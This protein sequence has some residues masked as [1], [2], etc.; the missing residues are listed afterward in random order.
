VRLEISLVRIHL[1][2][3]R[4]DYLILT[5]NETSGGRILALFEAC[6]KSEIG[7]SARHEQGLRRN[8]RAENS[9]Q[10]T[11]RRER[12]MPRVRMSNPD[13]TEGMRAPKGQFANIK[14]YPPADFRGVSKSRLH[15]QSGSCEQ[16]REGKRLRRITGAAPSPPQRLRQ[17]P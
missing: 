3:P 13:K 10:S 4:I 8:N 14:R 12:K 5:T 17:A 9:H 6:G 7:L 16:A 2:P 15:H 1:A 11:R